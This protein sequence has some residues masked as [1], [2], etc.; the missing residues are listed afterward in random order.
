MANDIYLGLD[1]GTSAV[2]AVLVDGT[3]RCL[4]TASQDYAVDHPFPGWAEQHP[5]RWWQAVEEVMGRLRQQAAEALAGTVAIGLS[6]QMHGLVLQDEAGDALRPALLWNDS[7]AERECRLLDAELPRLGELTGVGPMP[8]FWP[9]KL[10]WLS[11]HEPDVLARTRYLLLPKDEVRWRMSGER[12]TDMCDAAGTQLLD[13]ARRQWSEEVVAACGVDP[14]WL[15]RLV[16][17][18]EPAGRLHPELAQRWGLPEGVVIAGGAGDVAA[19][20]LGIGAIEDGSAFLTLGTS[21]QLFVSTPGYRPAPEHALHAFAHALPGRWFQMAALLNGASALSW[22]AGLMG[23]SIEGALARA[24]ARGD[25]PESLLFLPYLNGERTPH[26]DPAARG[27]LF[28]LTPAS[29]V[30]EV[31]RAVLSGVGYSL[32]E[33]MEVIESAGTPVARL[34]AIGGGTRSDLWLQLLA[35][36]LERPLVRYRDSETGPAFGAARLARLAVTGESPEAVCRVPE[37]DRVFTPSEPLGRHAASYAR[38]L[39]LYRVLKP[40]FTAGMRSPRG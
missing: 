21:S 16:E 36:I 28:G 33:A 1:I 8:A 13:Q 34:A 4:A 17:G 5:D 27:V 38:F 3:Q 30:G 22:V 26:D 2:K 15:P 23:V 29:D 9:A 39:R 6:G 14:A 7:R 19:G 25:A 40:E 24:E 31:T 32:R 10:R 11:G 37:I 35:D 18:S 12:V 20:A